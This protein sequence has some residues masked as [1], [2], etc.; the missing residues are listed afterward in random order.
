MFILFGFGKQTTK[1]HGKVEQKYCYHCHNESAWDLMSI[2]TWFTLF[3]IPVI[4][5]KSEHIVKC[6]ICN[7]Y[8]ALS[9]EEL[10]TYKGNAVEGDHASIPKQAK[11]TDTSGLTETQ[12]NYRMQMQAHKEA[13][14]TRKEEG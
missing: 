2:R 7:R 4:P 6:P 9:S 3:F 13:Q 12:K 5:Y 14:K 11:Q 1:N 8:E 10:N